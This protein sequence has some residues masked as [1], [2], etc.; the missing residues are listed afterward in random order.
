MATAWIKRVAFGKYV[1]KR[2][3]WFWWSYH[4]VPDILGDSICRTVGLRKVW[5]G[6]LAEARKIRKDIQREGL[7][8]E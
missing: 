8:H 5:V 6:S 7:V 1:V 4:T 2:K 3:V